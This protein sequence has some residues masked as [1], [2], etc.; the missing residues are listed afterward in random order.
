MWFHIILLASPIHQLC[1]QI[2]TQ[3][4]ILVHEVNELR[5]DEK[6]FVEN[7]RMEELKEL[8]IQYAYENENFCDS[9]QKKTGQ[10]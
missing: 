8:I 6:K 7:K 2:N 3:S 9:L 10:L 5:T 4:Q 1:N